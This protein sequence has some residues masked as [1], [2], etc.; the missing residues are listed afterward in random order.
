MF[1]AFRAAE[2]GEKRSLTQFWSQNLDSWY[3]DVTAILQCDHELESEK[4]DKWVGATRKQ[5]S[6]GEGEERR[7]VPISF[8][9]DFSRVKLLVKRPDLDLPPSRVKHG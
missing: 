7:P 1:A 6:K 8:N 3:F 2:I 9:R 5:A 4:R